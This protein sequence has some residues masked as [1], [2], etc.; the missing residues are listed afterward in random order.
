M[1]TTELIVAHDVRP[2][3]V[4]WAIWGINH[5]SWFDYDEIRPMPLTT[6]PPIRDDCSG[7]C[8]LVYFKA[9][10]PDPNGPT[11]NYD[12]YGDTDSL[13][14]NAKHIALEDVLPGD[15]AIF[16][17]NP[18]RHGAVIIS[19]GSDPMTS[20]HGSPNTPQ[21]ISVSD[22]RVA[23]QEAF[24]LPEP[25]VVTY[26]RY[27]TTDRRAP[28]PVPTKNPTPA[29][30]K[31]AGLVLLPDPAAAREAKSHGWT[32][33]VWGGT[34]FVAASSTEPKGTPEYASVDYKIMRTQLTN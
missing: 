24:G 1:A 7:W 18:T 16:G 13:Y 31:K 32:I 11:Y 10:A 4:S 27:D 14:D 6:N 26:C 20:S 2:D 34:S 15:I 21:R 33:Y 29:E 8:T 9:G 25:A 23:V 3:I 5:V 22:L 30:L 19:G 12:G 17:L 28:K